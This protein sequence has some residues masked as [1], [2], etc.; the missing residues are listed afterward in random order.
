LLRNSRNFEI[1]TKNSDSQ[2][3]TKVSTL[4]ITDLASSDLGQYEC[5]AVVNRQKD[6]AR[7]EVTTEG[8]A[9]GSK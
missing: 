5:R 6:S 1:N 3:L 2:I 8:A 4:K 7:F 9:P